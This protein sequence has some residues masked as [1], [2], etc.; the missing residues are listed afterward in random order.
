MTSGLMTVQ[1]ISSELNLR[2]LERKGVPSDQ[3]AGKLDI[4]A[5]P[6]FGMP[7]MNYRMK[8]P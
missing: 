7:R 2:R 8:Y 6:F 4:S 3:V 1:R 5:G